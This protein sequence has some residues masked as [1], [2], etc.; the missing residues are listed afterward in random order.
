MRGEETRSRL[1]GI[2]DGPPSFLLEAG[3]EKTKNDDRSHDI[4]ENK[5]SEFS[6][7]AENRQ[8]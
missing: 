5:R 7:W 3:Q 8:A 2:F 6:E 1:S 4:I